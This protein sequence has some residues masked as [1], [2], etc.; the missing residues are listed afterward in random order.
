MYICMYVTKYH[1]EQTVETRSANFDRRMPVEK[2]VHLL[3]FIEIVNVSDLNYQYQTFE[4]RT[5][6]T[7]WVIIVQT[8]TDTTDIAS[9]KTE[10]RL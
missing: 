1:R 6:G 9:A 2:Y 4:S 3:I 8:A 10:S 5:L 7:S